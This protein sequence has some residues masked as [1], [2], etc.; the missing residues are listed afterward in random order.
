MTPEVAARLT[1]HEQEAAE[2]TLGNGRAAAARGSLVA[3]PGRRIRIIEGGERALGSLQRRELLQR[4]LLAAGD[5]VA[6]TLSLVLVLSLLGAD[7]PGLV[8]LAGTPLLIVL[9]KIAGSTIAT[10][11]G[12]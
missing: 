8:A 1:V 12:S 2:P 3:L 9:F 4:R 10:S 7:R 11:C 6:A 5:V